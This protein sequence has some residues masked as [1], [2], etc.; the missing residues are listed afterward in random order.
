MDWG[1]NMYKDTYKNRILI[2]GLVLGIISVIQS[3]FHLEL[4]LITSAL[5]MI[6]LAIGYIL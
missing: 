4:S 6:A 5:S 1:L 2:S 3:M